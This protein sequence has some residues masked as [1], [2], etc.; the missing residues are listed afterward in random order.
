MGKST[1]VQL[2]LDLKR[3]LDS[4]IA[5]KK[6]SLE[7]SISIIRLVE[8]DIREIEITDEGLL[9]PD[10]IGGRSTPDFDG[11]LVVYNVVDPMSASLLPSLL[12]M[13]RILLCANNSHDAFENREVS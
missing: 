9:W 7:G 4:P 5:S 11:V 10:E 3:T 2:A 8:I 1:F 6:V 12:S 13:S